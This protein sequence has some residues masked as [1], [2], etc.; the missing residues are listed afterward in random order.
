MSYYCGVYL[1]IDND[2]VP[3]IRAK[4]GRE[5][6]LQDLTMDYQYA[7][8]KANYNSVVQYLVDE[9]KHDDMKADIF[10]GLH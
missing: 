3:V 5:E 6:E 9:R 7:L 1:F 10:S 8:K 2:I 4:R